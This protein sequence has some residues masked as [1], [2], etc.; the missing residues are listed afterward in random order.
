MLHMKFDFDWPSGLWGE[1]IE[2]VDNIHTYIQTT[3]AYLSYK[4]TTEPS[5]QVSENMSLPFCWNKRLLYI[6]S[7]TTKL[8]Q[9][10]YIQNIQFSISIRTLVD[11]LLFNNI[12]EKNKIEQ[13][14]CHVLF[15]QVHTMLFVSALWKK[16]VAKSDGWMSLGF[17]VPYNSISVIS[18]RWKG[19]HERLC[20]MKCCL[21]S[22][23]ISSQAGFEPATRWSE[24]GTARKPKLR[25]TK[26]PLFSNLTRGSY[27]NTKRTSHK[28]EQ[29]SNT[30]SILIP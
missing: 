3:E 30:F 11:V 13:I 5:A 22:G 7:F 12:F 28:T 1:D 4:L 29:Y 10:K 2:N 8:V 21:C 26:L 14:N 17:Y 15:K 24:V 9:I 25:P 19:E 6:K 16:C 20:A 27:G 23:R 18:G